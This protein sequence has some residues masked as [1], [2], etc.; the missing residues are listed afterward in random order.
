MPPSIK[1]QIGRAQLATAMDL[2]LHDKDPISV[3]CLACGGGEVVEGLARL[4]GAAPFSAQ[5]LEERPD[6]DERQLRGIRNQY[7][8][9]FKHL[10]TRDGMMR[11]DAALLHNF[12]DT[13][14]DTALF[15]GWRDYSTITGTL[16]VAVQVFQVW[17]YA[18]NEDKLAIGTDLE[19]I[20]EIFP[21]LT[22]LDRVEQKRALRNSIKKW[23]YDNAL[24]S[25]PATE[26]ELCA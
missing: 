23:R 10:T 5:I 16:P 24:L 22:E 11:D 26:P 19:E 7:W 12:N 15:V 8:N 14:N 6:L 21:R 18:Q 25:D 9:A 20:R 4:K 13:M 1:L 3:Q 17:W 2:F